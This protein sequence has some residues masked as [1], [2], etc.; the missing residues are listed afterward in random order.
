M[1]KVI[2]GIV[3]VVA[4]MGLVQ[5]VSADW[6]ECRHDVPPCKFKSIAPP[7]PP[8][9]TPKPTAT[10]APQVIVIQQPVVVVTAVP[11]RQAQ[12]AGARITPP[13]TGDGGLR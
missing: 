1:L 10:A 9:S 8:T 5:S 7:P 6:P 11:Q 13:R 4:S 2:A 3:I 12:V